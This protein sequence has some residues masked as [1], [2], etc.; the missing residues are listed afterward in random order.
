MSPRPQARH[1]RQGVVPAGSE[2][3]FSTAV[4]QF[5]GFHRW[6]GYHTHRSDRSPAGF[7]DWTF[8]RGSRLVFAELKRAGA[9]ARVRLDEVADRPEWLRDRAITN[10]QA[11]WL[12]A[13]RVV[14]DA[15]DA[16]M[17]GDDFDDLEPDPL[18]PQRPSIQVYVWTPNDWPEI[19][20]VLGAKG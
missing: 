18:V 9:A 8:V 15:C 13:L 14:Q 3:A 12:Q 7:P 17:P 20:R 2:D 6:R 4:Q 1:Y 10:A 11:S 19:E 16:W 5:A